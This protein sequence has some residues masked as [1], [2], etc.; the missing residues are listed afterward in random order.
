[1]YYSKITN[2]WDLTYAKPEEIAD[3]K[4]AMEF[5]NQYS[6]DQLIP[7]RVL[8]IGDRK[9]TRC[10]V[11]AGEGALY[12]WKVGQSVEIGFIRSLI[13][14]F[15]YLSE[16]C[17]RNID[18]SPY[19]D[20][21][22]FDS[23]KPISQG[24]YWP[25]KDAV[26][27]KGIF[28]FGIFTKLAKVLLDISDSLDNVDKANE[29]CDFIDINLKHFRRKSS[30]KHL[31]RSIELPQDMQWGENWEFECGHLCHELDT[32]FKNKYYFDQMDDEEKLSLIRKMEN[33]VEERG[34]NVQF[35]R[36]YALL[37][38][39]C[40]ELDEKE[41]SNSESDFYNPW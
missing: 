22:L 40:R 1:M 7:I 4:N 17:D 12:P 19:Q 26:A 10:I 27:Y 13:D 28:S 31:V 39:S 18:N 34:V 21:G 16:L 8:E 33:F 6:G 3:A 32:E 36:N 24:K 5:I 20:F 9:E 38:Q 35:I 23:I 25:D 14:R 41:N 15:R 37:D 29:K 30:M 11:L 2:V